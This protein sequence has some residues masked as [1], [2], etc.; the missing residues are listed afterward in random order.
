MIPGPLHWDSGVLAIGPPRKSLDLLFKKILTVALYG[1]GLNLF[2]SLHLIDRCPNSKAFFCHF[3]DV[4]FLQWRN[5]SCYC[6]PGWIGKGVVFLFIFVKSWTL[7][8]FFPFSSLPRNAE[9]WVKSSFIFL[10]Q[11]LNK[12]TFLFSLWF[13]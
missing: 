3:S 12:Q 1:I 13:G 5:S 7:P 6:W 10:N 11:C 4:M 8:P 9:N 2:I